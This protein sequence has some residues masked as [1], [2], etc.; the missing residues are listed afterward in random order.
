MQAHVSGF[1][2]AFQWA[3]RRHFPPM[4]FACVC[5]CV[6]VCIKVANWFLWIFASKAGE[7]AVFRPPAKKKKATCLIKL[8]ETEKK[9]NSETLKTTLMLCARA[10]KF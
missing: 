3:C 4:R 7:N 1:F 8:L 2:I 6:G 9:S 5:V 10:S